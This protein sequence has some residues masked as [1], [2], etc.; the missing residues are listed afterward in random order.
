MP[1]GTGYITDL[2]MTGPVHSILGVTPADVI[3][4]MRTH[5]PRRF[6][7][8]EGEIRASGALFEINPV[9]GKTVSVTRVSF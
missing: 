1:N 7:V 6:T 3:E 2:G 5:M 8:A 4:K 9:S